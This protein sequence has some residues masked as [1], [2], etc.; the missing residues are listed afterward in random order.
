[1][2]A[3]LLALLAALWVPS[4]GQQGGGRTAGCCGP[5]VGLDELEC[6]DS[7]FGCAA[8][9]WRG[10][11]AAFPHGA[12]LRAFG[13]V[14]PEQAETLHMLVRV[15]I[16]RYILDGEETDVSQASAGGS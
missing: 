11:Q 4:V 2:R 1:M 9:A 14:L 16:A 7:A 6:V 13:Q 3:L 12:A 10:R 5:H 8:V 15:A